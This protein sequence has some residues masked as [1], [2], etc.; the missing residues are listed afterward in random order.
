MSGSENGKIL[1]TFALIP[2]ITILGS[3]IFDNFVRK[4]QDGDTSASTPSSKF[5]TSNSMSAAHTPR[6]GSVDDSLN[7]SVTSLSSSIEHPLDGLS[8]SQTRTPHALSASL[9]ARRRGS[10]SDDYADASFRGIRSTTSSF[11]DDD[12]S[13]EGDPKGRESGEASARDKALQD[14]LRANNSN[15]NNNDINGEG[16]LLMSKGTNYT[17]QES[18]FS[19]SD[20]QEIRS[21]GSSPKKGS[22]KQVYQSVFHGNLFQSMH[23]E[24]KGIGSLTN[25]GL[26]QPLVVAMVGLPARGKSYIV[27]MIIR[28]L[29]WTGI[30]CKVF[31]VGAH[32]RKIGLESAD[33]SF[34]DKQ[35]SDGN[36]KRE[37]MAMVV[38]EAMYKWL[39]GSTRKNR[40]A[41]F[42]ATNTTKGRRYALAQRARAES[43]F[44]LFVESICDDQEVLNRNYDLKLKN[45]DYKDMPPDKAKADF[46]KR[47]SAIGLLLAIA[48]LR[49]MEMMLM[50]MI[51]MSILTSTISAPRCFLFICSSPSPSFH[52]IPSLSHYTLLSSSSLS[53]HR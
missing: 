5:N 35:N 42:D 8:S 46:L 41:F 53:H 38:Q 6:R 16:S 29:T 45:E 44:L 40:V 17:T 1:A 28:F 22:K 25:L 47:V 48:L 27:K 49:E 15:T 39:H 7:M 32:R 2:A 50:L 24:E 10:G 43:T 9:A 19:T 31:N 14:I 33:A 4:P 21:G 12:E 18:T 37:E 36:R 3:Y 23:T 52:R 20:D 11:F 13:E 51:M 26:E 34:F 30:E